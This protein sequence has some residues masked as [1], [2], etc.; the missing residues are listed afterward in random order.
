MAAFKT[1]GEPKI[2]SASL[3]NSIR[4]WDAAEMKTL[5]MV[6]AP[7]KSEISSITFLE[8]CC[9]VAT[10]H[11]DGLIRLWNLEINSSI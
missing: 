2:I 6:E 10:G 3:D 11:E 9:L 5:S 1:Q 7:E 8:R 4:F